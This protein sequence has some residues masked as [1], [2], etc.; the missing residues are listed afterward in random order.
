MALCY[1][2]PQFSVD[3]PGHSGLGQLGLA[4]AGRSDLAS[5]SHPA[6]GLTVM[7]IYSTSRKTSSNMREEALP[8]KCFSGLCLHHIYKCSIG[9]RRSYDQAR[10]QGLWDQFQPSKKEWQSHCKG[11]HIKNGK[12][13]WLTILHS[14]TQALVIYFSSFT[15]SYHIESEYSW[16]EKVTIKWCFSLENYKQVHTHY[17]FG[18]RWL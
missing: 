18:R 10:T 9:R 16:F 6:V 4:E 2:F 5:L 17:Y 13:W 11:A 1:F 12:A 8:C 7:G 15:E 14:A 3:L